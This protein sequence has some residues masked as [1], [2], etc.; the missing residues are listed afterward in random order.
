MVYDEAAGTWVPKW[1]Y[2]GSN[3]AEENQWLVEVDDKKASKVGK[4]VD[5]FDPR[6]L[7]RQERLDRI[8]KNERQMKK[9][10]A[11]KGSAVGSGSFKPRGGGV[12]KGKGRK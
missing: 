7:S 5:E 10:T 4:D 2:K 3:K 9:N 8:K 12:K 1:G 11:G 6:K